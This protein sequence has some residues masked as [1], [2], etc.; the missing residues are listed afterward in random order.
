MRNQA[1]RVR[2]YKLAERGAVASIRCTR[3][4]SRWLVFHTAACSR[5]T[6]AVA[7]HGRSSTG[8]ETGLHLLGW[9]R[10]HTGRSRL[11]AIQTSVTGILSL[12]ARYRRRSWRNP[13]I[14]L[15][16]GFG[17]A[18]CPKR[19][20][21]KGVKLGSRAFVPLLYVLQTERADVR[22]LFK[23]SINCVARSPTT[24]ACVRASGLRTDSAPWITL[25]GAEGGW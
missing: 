23:T 4:H 14:F 3:R 7:G 19:R 22:T 10:L 2:Q 24:C 5:R 16:A 8:I 25:T 18:P 20:T 1:P 6:G 15:V 17:S 9:K 13:G 12:A 11:P 21:T